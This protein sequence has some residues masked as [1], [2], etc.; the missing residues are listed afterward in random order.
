MIV[1]DIETTGVDYTKNSI[2]SIGALDFLNPENQFYTECRIWD[3]AE[4]TAK[5][6]EINGFS[7]AQVKDKTKMPLEEAIKQFLIWTGKIKEPHDLTIAGENPR[8]DADFLRTS[9]ERYRIGWP[10]SHRTIDLHTE[11]YNHM[12]KRGIKIPLNKSRCSDIKLDT[13]LKYVGL[14]EE[15]MPHHALRGAKM[16]AEAFSRL[17]YGKYLLE[18]FKNF[19]RPACLIQIRQ[20]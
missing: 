19:P 12:V 8:F 6:L 4:I 9:A 16:E 14:P 3:G 18:E 2:V 7:E 20:L 10:L 17:I 13:T 11:S 1:V 15:P 5:A